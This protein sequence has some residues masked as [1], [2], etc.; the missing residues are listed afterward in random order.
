MSKVHLFVDVL[1]VKYAVHFTG[2]RL[3]LVFIYHLF[4]PKQNENL[5]RLPSNLRVYPVLFL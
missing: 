3:V 2:C 1:I 4:E 5:S